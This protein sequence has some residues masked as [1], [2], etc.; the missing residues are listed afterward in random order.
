N[1]IV[2]DDGRARLVDFGLVRAAGERAEGGGTEDIAVD[3]LTRT[4][5]TV[6]TPAYMA[7]EQ[8]RGGAVDPRVDQFA[9]CIT[10]CQA[11]T[12][13]YPLDRAG[14][15]PG[16]RASVARAMPARLRRPLARGLAIRPADRF[17]SMD[18]LLAA[19]SG[20]R[21][22]RRLAWGG[23]ALGAAIVATSVALALSSAPTSSVC[24]GADRHFGRVWDGA[25]RQATLA[26]F[27]SSGHPRGVATFA[28]VD[29]ALDDFGRDWTSAH[30][31]ACRDTRVHRSRSEEVLEVRMRCLETNL[32]Q[33]HALIEKLPSMEAAT[34]DRALPAVLSLPAG[35]SCA[36][37]VTSGPDDDTAGVT[38]SLVRSRAARADALVSL[39]RFE[40]GVVEATA[41]EALAREAGAVGARRRA[42]LSL[43]KARNKAGRYAEAEQSLRELIRVASGAAD[44]RAVAEAWIELVPVLTELGR[45]GDAV[46]IE[47]AVDAAIARVGGDVALRARSVRYQSEARAWQLDYERAV[48]QADESV[49]LAIEAHGE[50][51]PFVAEARAN[52]AQLLSEVEDYDRAR[53]VIEQAIALNTELFGTAHPITAFTVA[54]KGRIAHLRG[55]YPQARELLDHAVAQISSSSGQHP[56]LSYIYRE[57][58]WL[59][60]SQGH[61][62]AARTKF[63]QALARTRAEFGPNDFRVAIYLTD[64]AETYVAEDR[65][66]EAFEAL[67]ESLPIRA[68]SRG[69]GHVSVGRGL[70]RLGRIEFQRRNFGPALALFERAMPIYLALGETERIRTTEALIAGT[71]WELGRDRA[72]NLARVR[73]AA[74]QL[75]ELSSEE[76]EIVDAWLADKPATR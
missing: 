47:G 65:L 33:A 32:T 73:V 27:E 58:G 4:G 22:R 74:A 49:A 8:R 71:S 17:E 68:T 30:T 6:G 48:P 64:L 9:F 40:E 76:V 24:T 54:I 43:G 37:L 23:A 39:G 28:R 59:E 31:A 10:A 16:M 11:L 38:A 72:A 67:T 34:L 70:E 55:D 35:A 14:A 50:T 3:S 15:V 61:I 20:E 69:A 62:A 1:I 44:D 51:H 2:G 42:L 5:E 45:F 21:R 18:A 46:A 56:V 29:R 41:A 75:R 25:A 63:E 36:S 26:A 7:P 57:Q 13:E 66:D 52:L 19:L 53:D 12:G 60:L